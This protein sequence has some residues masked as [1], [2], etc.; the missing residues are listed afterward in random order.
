MSGT[1]DR[2][3]RKA[4]GQTCAILRLGWGSSNKTEGQKGRRGK[5]RAVSECSCDIYLQTSQKENAKKLTQFFFDFSK[6]IL[7]NVGFSLL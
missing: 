7:G 1:N 4:T 6:K 3:R 5:K 2:S